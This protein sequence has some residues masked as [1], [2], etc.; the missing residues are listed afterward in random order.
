MRAENEL[1]LLT[2]AINKSESEIKRIEDILSEPVDWGYIIGQLIHHRLTGYFMMG[3][4]ETCTKYLFKEVRKQ[5][6]L[7]VKLNKVLTRENMDYMQKIFDE[8]EKENVKYAGLKGVIFNSSLYELG[9]RRSND[10]D[11][12]VH[13]A[14]LKK[15]DEILRKEGFIQ[16]L[17]S[18]KGEASKKDK[19]IQRLHHHDLIPYYKKNE[20]F[21]LLAYF[22]ID[23]NFR[24]DDG[25]DKETLTEKVFDYGTIIYEENGYKIRGLR[26]EGH[27]LH[28]CIHFS[29]EASHSLWVSD[30]RDCMIYKLI[31]IENTIRSIGVDKL[32]KWIKEVSQFD[33]NREIYFTLFYLNQFYPN[34][35]YERIM[36]MI[37]TDK[38]GVDE[39]AILGTT[40]V[41]KRKR[42]FVE[43]AFD[44]KYSI[45][46]SN[47]DYKKVD[48]Q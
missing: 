38:E 2:S 1:I 29:R 47:N 15:I 7:I 11:I 21:E 18:D 20:D 36:E 26:W 27:L 37:K 5:L 6:D 42:S 30:K 17:N 39:I 34:T 14:D 35:E 12:L 44:L 32:E 45:D 43:S 8:F 23:I 46:F 28:L 22:K 48:L 40:D 10:I 33:C 25:K 24:I 9:M 31:D 4:P 19:I 13:E 3:L 41:V 16:A